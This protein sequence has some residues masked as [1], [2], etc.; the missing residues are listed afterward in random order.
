MTALAPWRSPL[1]RAL[2][3]NRALA[4]ARYFQLATLRAEGV[5]ANRTVVF[6]GFLPD[7]NALLAITDRRNQKIAQI[8]HN[9]HSEICWYFPKTREQFRLS[10]LLYS[11][12]ASHDNPAWQRAYSATWLQLSPA[13][14]A[15]FTSVNSDLAVTS[16]PTR[17]ANP[18]T[19]EPP[20][21]FRL[22]IFEPT[23][24]EHLELQPEPSTGER[25]HPHQAHLYQHE[26][27]DKWTT[28]A[29]DL[30]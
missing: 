22:L 20:D 2:H 26:P 11:V 16:D 13:A 6:R 1:A 25:S 8:A 9:P 18:D 21:T 12:D 10:G 28:C 4:Y 14:R 17:E 27:P 3:R 29:V 15:Q 23:V 24:V 30:F 19:S 7:S 5:P